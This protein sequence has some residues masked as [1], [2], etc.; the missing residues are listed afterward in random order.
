[1]EKMVAWETNSKHAEKKYQYTAIMYGLNK[2]PYCIMHSV[3]MLCR[4]FSKHDRNCV[5]HW[6]TCTLYYTARSDIICVL[7]LCTTE[8]GSTALDV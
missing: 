6:H 3:C 2:S 8:M 7:Y 4:Q 1:M 5:V